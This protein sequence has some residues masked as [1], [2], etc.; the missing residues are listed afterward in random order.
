MTAPVAVLALAMGIGGAAAPAKDPCCEAQ[1]A[2][3]EALHEARQ[4]RAAHRAYVRVARAQA[5]AGEFSGDALLSAAVMSHH[6]GRYRRAAQE[7]DNA[8]RI[9]AEF[10]RTNLQVRATLEAAVLY[11]QLGLGALTLARAERV[12]AL[13][14]APEVSDETRELVERRLQSS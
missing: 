8:A 11:H 12:N 6:L 4:F 13:V 14:T 7:L 5:A 9:A 10:G 1:I 3:A 2:R